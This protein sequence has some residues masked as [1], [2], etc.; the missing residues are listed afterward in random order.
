MWQIY[1]S[2]KNLLNVKKQKQKQKQKQNKN[3]K[4]KKNNQKEI[5]MQCHQFQQTTDE[6]TQVSR[7]RQVAFPYI[8]RR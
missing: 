8:A 2:V 6:E 4:K 7:L 3:K 5:T 1:Q